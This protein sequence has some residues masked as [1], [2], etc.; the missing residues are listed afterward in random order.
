MQVPL[1]L[2]IFPPMAKPE[3]LYTV[4]WLVDELKSELSRL[5]LY[6]KLYSHNP[7]AFAGTYN[8]RTVLS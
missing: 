1:H 4:T 8:G 5:L 3:V 2:I 6:V 7:P